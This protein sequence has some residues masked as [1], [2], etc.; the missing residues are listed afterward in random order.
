M[1][2]LL[3]RKKEKLLTLDQVM[4]SLDNNIIYARKLYPTFSDDVKSRIQRLYGMPLDE[5][6]ESLDKKHSE[7][8]LVLEACPQIEEL[9]PEKFRK[10]I[11]KEV[12]E[13]NRSLINILRD[14]E[15]DTG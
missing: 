5:M 2:W 10:K 9:M 3:K 7:M 15:N 4:S 6:I 1:I 13:L 8:K 12:R 11:T 14:T